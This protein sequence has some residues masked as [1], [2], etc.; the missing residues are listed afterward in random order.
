MI[1]A[2]LIMHIYRMD[3]I[4]KYT[5]SSQRDL[6]IDM[7]RGVVMFMLVVV[8]IEVFSIFNYLAWERLG[9]ITSAEGFVIFSGLVLGIVHRRLQGNNNNIIESTNKLFFRSIQIYKAN[10]AIVIILY[11]LVY[12]SLPGIEVITTFKKWSTGDIYKLMP[13]PEWSWNKILIDVLMLKHSPHQI[14]I[15]GLYVLLLAFSPVVIYL[16][17]KNHWG[18]VLTVITVLYL[19]QTTYP[20]RPSKA[21]FEYAFPL[22]SWQFIF[23]SALI[24]G[25]FFEEIKKILIKKKYFVIS[26]LVIMNSY[27]VFFAWN[28]PNQAFPEWPNINYYSSQEFYFLHNKWYGKSNLGVLRIINNIVFWSFVYFLLTKFWKPINKLIGW[29][30]IPIGQYSL[31]VFIMHLPIIYVL[32]LVL[33]YSSS[34]PHFNGE[35]I[36]QNSAIHIIAIMSLWMMVKFKFLI[37][38]IPN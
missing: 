36:I 34:A 28:S 15:L 33:E 37:K 18:L 6:R 29:I 21:Q 32:D 7:M 4:V 27:F 23:Y 5:D 10:I 25:Y 2:G 9:V 24:A 1:N 22:L 13:S 20:S 17:K 19:Y 31:Y 38:Y 8:H 12:L 14:Q 35:T 16:L 3:F 30:F 26:V 11:V